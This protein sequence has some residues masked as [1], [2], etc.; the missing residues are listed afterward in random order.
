[1]LWDAVTGR[2]PTMAT[3]IVAN[4]SELGGRGHSAFHWNPRRQTS[5]LGWLRG[6]WKGGTHSRQAIALS[7]AGVAP[8]HFTLSCRGTYA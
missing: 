6:F 3:N 7:L 5:R 8:L 2:D 1:M 4:V